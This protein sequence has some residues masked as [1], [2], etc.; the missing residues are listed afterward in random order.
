[1]NQFKYS[2]KIFGV[3]AVLF[4]I[5]ATFFPRMAIADSLTAPIKSDCTVVGELRIIP[6][7]KDPNEID[8]L[9][10]TVISY[11]TFKLQ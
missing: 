5:C 11:S 10:P 8:V 4:V 6:D 1:M 7:P 3:I 9:P 2:K